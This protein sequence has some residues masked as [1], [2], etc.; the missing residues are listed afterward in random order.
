M[1]KSL[2]AIALAATANIAFADN[3]ISDVRFS[4]YSASQ[5]EVF[6]TRPDNWNGQ[7]SCQVQI[8]E[9]NYP[10]TIYTAEESRNLHAGAPVDLSKNQYADFSVPHAYRGEQKQVRVLC[11]TA[12]GQ[13]QSISTIAAP[14]TVKVTLQGTETVDGVFNVTGGIYVEGHANGTFCQSADQQNAL[15]GQ[16]LFTDELNSTGG[17]WANFYNVQETVENLYYGYTQTVF[18]CSSEG[19]TTVTLVELREGANQ[20]LEVTSEAIYYK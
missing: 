17:Y 9:A 12:N 4:K 2:I 13:V 16:Y 14:P 6:F 3:Q 11:D 8:R 1:K 15:H 20:T 7:G 19:G 18:E 5:L 10:Y